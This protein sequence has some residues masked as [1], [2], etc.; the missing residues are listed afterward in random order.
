[1]IIAISIL[2]GLAIYNATN[3]RLRDRANL[4]A[5]IADLSRGCA[6]L[7][8]Q[9]AE[10]GRRTAATG[11][12]GRP[13]RERRGEPRRA[14]DRIASPPSSASSATWSSNWPRPSRCTS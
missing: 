2:T 9:V 7:A 4:A 5:Q 10:V 11:N 6:D 12:P 1:M 3:N 13:D 8:R 14:R